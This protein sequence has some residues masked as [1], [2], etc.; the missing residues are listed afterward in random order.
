MQG[1]TIISELVDAAYDNNAQVVTGNCNCIGVMGALLGG[2]YSRLMGKHGFMVDNVL[3]LNIV[4]GFGV[5]KTIT[6]SADPD[7]WFALRGAG[8]NFA[9][10][11]SAVMKAYPTPQAQNGA[12]L[13]PL[14]FS[15]DSIEALVTAINGL[16]LTP[17]MAI[18]LYYAT[19]G[20]PD[21][22]PAVIAFPFYLGSEASG[23][24]AFAS[25]F[26]VHPITDGTTWTPYNHVND[27]SVNFCALGG[28]KPS[29]GAA[30]AQLDPATWRTLWNEYTAFLNTNGGDKVG[31]STILIE[32]YSLG[33]AQTAGDS[34]S[35]YA[36]RST[37]RFNMVVIAWYNDASFDATGT[38]W[39]AGIRD[40]L[41][42]T[43]GLPE[44]PTY[45]LY[46][47]PFPFD[48]SVQ[49]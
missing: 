38:S 45:A 23:R 2:G 47:S 22:T 14:I 32:A 37:N 20:A 29:Y 13:G 33:V 18:F 39:A 12:W 24:S 31:N 5:S 35:A 10:V 42:N 44:D 28:R 43:G 19:S 1:G 7:L 36:W 25:I 26:A 34:S 21:Y 9:I 15:P 11:T 46:L 16:T 27:G 48:S 41:R 3:S 8:A 17:E 40:L 30:A 6:A 4:T 49:V